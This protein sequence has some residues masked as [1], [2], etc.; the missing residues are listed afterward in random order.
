MEDA[1]FGER[2]VMTLSSGLS[3][4]LTSRFLPA[5]PAASPDRAMTEP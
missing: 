5:S 4:T 3:P 1:N 2:Q